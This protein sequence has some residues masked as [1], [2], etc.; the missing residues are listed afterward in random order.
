MNVHSVIVDISTPSQLTNDGLVIYVGTRIQTHQHLR[1]QLYRQVD[2][3]FGGMHVVHL[4]GS[5]ANHTARLERAKV[6][7]VAC[8]N[9]RLSIRLFRRRS[10]SG[11]VL[12]MI[13]MVVSKDITLI[14]QCR[15]NG[16]QELVLGMMCN[17]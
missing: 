1:R 6:G 14:Q 15:L 4:Q 7:R 11:H 9:I 17:H 3:G 8:V 10:R 5:R 13:K 12:V 2:R 16:L